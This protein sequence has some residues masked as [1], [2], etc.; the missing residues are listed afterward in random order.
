MTVPTNIPETPM[1]HTKHKSIHGSKG[2]KHSI[3]MEVLQHVLKTVL[4]ARDD[5]QINSFS[6]WVSYRGYQDFDDVCEHLCC[7]SDDL[8]KYA[9]YRVKGIKYHLNSNIIHKL[10][11]FNNWMSEK[12]RDGIYIL[13]NE[14]LTSLTRE[15]FIEFF[16]KTSD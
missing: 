15:Q 10:E 16:E 2:M 1:V 5:D 8:G 6:H 14:F 12:M 13:H 11:M 7:I 9:E 3:P 4:G